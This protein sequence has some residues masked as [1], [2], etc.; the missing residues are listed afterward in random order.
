M[1]RDSILVHWWRR[2][3]E[4]EYFALEQCVL[5][6]KMHSLALCWGGVCVC[7]C[8]TAR[9]NSA[10]KQWPWEKTQSEMRLGAGRGGGGR[11]SEAGQCWNSAVRPIA[12][13]GLI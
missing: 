10:L 3:T 7:V 9:D 6:V 8:F 1:V 13:G 2:V 5:H 4:I 11:R 12:L